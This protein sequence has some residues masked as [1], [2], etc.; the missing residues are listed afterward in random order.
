MT[1]SRKELA[2]EIVRAVIGIPQMKPHPDLVKRVEEILLRE[3]PEKAAVVE[4]AIGK[5]G[6]YTRI[7]GERPKPLPAVSIG[8]NATGTS[9]PTVLDVEPLAKEIERSGIIATGGG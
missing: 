8:Q 3:E 9:V 5:L 6:A 2:K 4:E 1:V 7:T